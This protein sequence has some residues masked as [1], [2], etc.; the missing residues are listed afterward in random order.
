M[1]G[2]DVTLALRALSTITTVLLSVFL[3]KLY[4]AR[5]LVRQLQKQGFVREVL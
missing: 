5:H 4:K 1:G 2:V 3:I